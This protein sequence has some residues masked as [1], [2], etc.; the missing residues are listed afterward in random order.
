MSDKTIYL[1]NYDVSVMSPSWSHPF[2][3]DLT[4][5]DFKEMLEEEGPIQF[6][7]LKMGSLDIDKTEPYWKDETTVTEYMDYYS[8]FDKRPVDCWLW[9]K[10]VV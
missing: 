7:R 1:Y 4:L 6:L 5:G 2:E 3:P 8:R 9:Y 10:V